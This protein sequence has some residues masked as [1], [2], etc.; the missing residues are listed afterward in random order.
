LFVFIGGELR[1]EAAEPDLEPHLGVVGD[2]AGQP[3]GSKRPDVAGAIELMKASPL[4]ARRV[5]D[6][7]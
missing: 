4:K 3:I 7:V 1:G 2:E 5:A 6:V